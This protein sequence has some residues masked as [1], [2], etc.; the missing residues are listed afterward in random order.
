MH[1]NLSCFSPHLPQTADSPV[2]TQQGT[3]VVDKW[4]EHQSSE[5]HWSQSLWA[6]QQANS[7]QLSTK[8]VVYKY[9]KLSFT[10]NK[11]RENIKKK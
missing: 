9:D 10:N 3:L 5:S 7:G 1:N 8:K 4:A 6:D 2:Y 11:I